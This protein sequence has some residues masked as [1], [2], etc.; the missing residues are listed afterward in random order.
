V[1]SRE[2]ST[3]PTT[4]QSLHRRQHNIST[5]RGLYHKP[6]A[7]MRQNGISPIVTMFI[8][9]LSVAQMLKVRDLVNTI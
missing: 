5:A 6:R 3:T 9:V 7:T 1:K 4:L 2:A 8:I